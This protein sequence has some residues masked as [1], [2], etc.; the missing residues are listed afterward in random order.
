VTP[1][2]NEFVALA[3][4]YVA[5]IDQA[6]ALGALG[7]LRVCAESPATPLCGGAGAAA[8]L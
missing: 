6:E 5:A 2:I 1:E 4:R 3:R 7:L 8:A